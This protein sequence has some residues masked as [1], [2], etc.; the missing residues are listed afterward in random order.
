MGPI[1]FHVVV[2]MALETER[3]NSG[4]GALKLRGLWGIPAAEEEL[5]LS[6]LYLR[7]WVMVE[8][9]RRARW[10]GADGHWARY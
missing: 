3:L 8:N 5:K 9:P 2:S 10:C 1:T 6:G 4:M 7:S